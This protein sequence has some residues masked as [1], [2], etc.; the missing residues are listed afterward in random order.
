PIDY[1][2]WNAKTVENLNFSAVEKL[3]F[4]YFLTLSL[5]PNIADSKTLY[6]SFLAHSQL[7]S[8]PLKILHTII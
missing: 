4:F 7:P 6:F 3:H 5:Q 8:I 2:N 1:K